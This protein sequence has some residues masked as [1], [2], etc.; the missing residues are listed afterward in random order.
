MS[1]CSNEIAERINR[2]VSHGVRLKFSGVGRGSDTPTNNFCLDLSPI[3]R[4]FGKDSLMIPHHPASSIFHCLPPSPST[5]PASP[6][7]KNFDRTHGTLAHFDKPSFI[8]YMQYE[9][10]CTVR[11]SNVISLSEDV[12]YEQGTS[13]TFCT[14]GYYLKILLN[15]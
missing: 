7:N 12:Q 2:R 3:L 8:N 4:R 9:G 1:T 15:E 10:G 6:F 13:S 11:V 5:T 14:G